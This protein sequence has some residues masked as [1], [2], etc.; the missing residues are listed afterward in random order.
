MSAKRRRCSSTRARMVSPPASASAQ[1]RA[2]TFN[3]I[4]HVFFVFLLSLLFCSATQNDIAPN[5]LGWRLH[6]LWVRLCVVPTLLCSSRLPHRSTGT[7]NAC[8]TY[9]SQSNLIW[10][11]PATWHCRHSF[12]GV[13]IRKICIK[14][15]T[16]TAE[17]FCH[18]SFGRFGSFLAWN[19]R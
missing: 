16:K 15:K 11:I 12:V 7:K 9:A 19:S 8:V 14:S 2:T 6:S 13:C 1:H 17:M 10:S 3:R 4:L 18:I 5:I